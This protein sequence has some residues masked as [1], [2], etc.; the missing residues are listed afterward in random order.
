MENKRRKVM[1]RE[2][3]KEIL[4]RVGPHNVSDQI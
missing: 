4:G 2:K 3:K 1:R